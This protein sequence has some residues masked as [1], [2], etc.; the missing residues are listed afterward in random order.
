MVYPKISVKKHFFDIKNIV[1]ISDDEYQQFNEKNILYTNL[2]TK[3]NII[4]ILT[5]NPSDIID[6]IKFSESY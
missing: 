4:K 2:E 1:D 5:R 6:K 3:I